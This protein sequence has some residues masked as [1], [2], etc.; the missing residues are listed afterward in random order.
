MN[1]QALAFLTMFSLIL[2]LSVYYVTL[3]S[4]T[5]VMK[6]ENSSQKEESKDNSKESTKETSKQEDQQK[7]QD[8]TRTSQQNAT[9][10]QQQIDNKKEEEINKNSSIVADTDSDDAKKKEALATIDELK[11]EKSMEK[12]IGDALK[13]AGYQSAVEIN[14][15]TCIV[16]VFEQ[17]DSKDAAK[18]IMN[19]VSELTN[20]KYL[21]EVTFK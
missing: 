17:E 12:T 9:K 6:E 5:T 20:N 21:I 2:M 1:K 18:I 4:D 7:K 13:K 8:N 3:P 15:D 11:D 10:L 16:N 19:T 14:K